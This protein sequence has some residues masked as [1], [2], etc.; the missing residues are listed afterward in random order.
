MS[1]DDP[2]WLKCHLKSQIILHSCLHL[3]VV[4]LKIRW[5]SIVSQ[6]KQ[7]LRNHSTSSGARHC[8]DFVTSC[9][10]S[11]DALCPRGH[12]HLLPEHRFQNLCWWKGH[13]HCADC[14]P[15][16]TASN[17][18]PH[19][20][21]PSAF[22]LQSQKPRTAFH[23]VACLNIKWFENNFCKSNKISGKILQILSMQ[24]VRK[25]T[26]VTYLHFNRLLF[27]LSLPLSLPSLVIN[28][29]PHLLLQCLFAQV[30]SSLLFL[31]SLSH[32]IS[33]SLQIDND[34]VSSL[35]MP[36]VPEC[37]DI[38]PFV[39]WRETLSIQLSRK[40]CL[41]R[42]P[43]EIKWAC[44]FAGYGEV[45]TCVK[46]CRWSTVCH[47]VEYGRWWSVWFWCVCGVWCSVVCE[48]LLHVC[49]CVVDCR[50][51]WRHNL[52][53]KEIHSHSCCFCA[54]VWNSHHVDIRSTAQK[55]LCVNSSWDFHPKNDQQFIAEL[56]SAQP[57]LERRCVSVGVAALAVVWWKT[58]SHVCDG[59]LKNL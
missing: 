42:V 41:E 9:G 13:T 57:K 33:A 26:T 21:L 52:A 43:L 16:S 47:A 19:P 49:C 6:S 50:Q 29:S 20:P 36:W 46:M 30:S 35:S 38:G 37:M 10:Y 40:T 15:L 7:N 25:I 32:L 22:L 2:H 58:T 17:T 28:L 39:V 1:T 56:S 55:S 18:M 8:V 51:T 4:V 24:K 23:A 53:T 11:I 34:N 44:T 48:V 5:S 12:I 59:L 27:H 45:F 54:L 14:N 31:S 3:D